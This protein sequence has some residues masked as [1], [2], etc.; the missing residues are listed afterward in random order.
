MGG[1]FWEMPMH[2]IARRN[3]MKGLCM[4]QHTVALALAVS[5]ER[6]ASLLICLRAVGAGS[7]RPC[8]HRRGSGANASMM[9]C[10]R[11]DAHHKQSCPDGQSMGSA[12]QHRRRHDIFRREK[13]FALPRRR[14]RRFDL[15]CMC[16]GSS[17]G[18]KV[19]HVR[20]HLVGQDNAEMR[21]L[22]CDHICC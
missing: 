12:P 17:C 1:K 10:E 8:A 13:G 19:A 9:I 7:A 6:A 14:G 15:K 2:T 20:W 22:D 4:P 11:T 18:R 5:T 3:E 16:C 21:R